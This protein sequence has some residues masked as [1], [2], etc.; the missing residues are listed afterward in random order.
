MRI[1]LGILAVYLFFLLIS[2]IDFSGMSFSE[3]KLIFSI[4]AGIAVVVISA[5]I[6]VSIIYSALLGFV[7]FAILYALILFLIEHI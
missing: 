6:G 5:K 1:I 3:I 7:T 4:C 2:N